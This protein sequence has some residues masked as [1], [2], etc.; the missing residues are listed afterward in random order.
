MFTFLL[1]CK[2]LSFTFYEAFN[3]KDPLEN[4]KTNFWLD[5]N[6][7]NRQ[8]SKIASIVYKPY[9]TI[10]IEEVFAMFSKLRYNVKLGD[11]KF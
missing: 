6:R 8:I 11:C 1:F 7:D 4:F 5:D 3:K 2:C 10:R 9:Q